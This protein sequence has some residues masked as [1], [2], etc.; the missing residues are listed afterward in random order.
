M[1]VIRSVNLK[2]KDDGIIKIMLGG[3][4]L[5]TTGIVSFFN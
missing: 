2:K 4:L 5:A 1:L 3:V